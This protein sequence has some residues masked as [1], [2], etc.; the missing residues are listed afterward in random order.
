MCGIAGII[1]NEHSRGESSC[2]QHLCRSL[3][4]RGPDDLG[5]L[6]WD[7]R[8]SVHVARSPEVVQHQWVGLLHCRLAIVDLSET[9]WQP[10]STPDG[11]YHLVFNGEIYNYL[12]LRA[13]LERLGY[14]FRSHSDSEVLL[15]AYAHWGVQMLSR[16]VGMFAFA[17]LD[18]QARTLILVR[19]FFGI[20]PLYY[21]HGPHG[22]LFASEIKTLLT[23]PGVPR[24]AHP[25]RLYDYLRFGLTDHGTDTLF[26]NIQQIPAAH[27]LQLPLDCPQQGQ[28]VHY[29]QVDHAQ[30]LML[31]F[32]EAASTLR[33][34]FLD[35]VRLH[36][37][38]D[39]PVGAAL[40]GGIDSSAIVMAMRYLQGACLELHT[41]S[42]IA[43][44][45]SLN[46]ELWVD[47]VCQASQ[48]VSH[49]VHL[50]PEALL[51]DLDTLMAIQEEPFGS[52][53]LYAQM[54]VFRLAHE[55]GIKVMLDGQGADELFGGYR[56]HLAARLASLVR[57][58]Q[59]GQAGHLL[60]QA[61]HL[62]G[63][64]RLMMLSRALGVLAWA[65]QRL[66]PPW[67]LKRYLFPPWLNASWFAEHS[68]VAQPI[69]HAHEREVLREHLAQALTTN[70]L[71]MLLRYEDRSSMAFAVESRTPFLTP[72]LVQ[73]V[74]ALPE[75][76]LIAADGTSKAVFR[77]AM[78]GLVPNAIL[79]RQDKIGFATPERHWLPILRPWANSVLQSE[80]AQTLP[81]IRL[82]VI[83]QQWQAICTGRQPWDVRVWRWLN[84]ICWAQHFQVRFAP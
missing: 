59:W 18:T 5:Y 46:E 71:P 27:Y 67:L 47:L 69:W 13:E 2:V 41:F 80:V 55:S 83:Q 12:E 37:R 14:T 19:D 79:D 25:Q 73:Y 33:D 81:A 22:F 45:A 48:A 42:Y 68:T 77:R 56:P 82:N 74:S 44:D 76:Y 43:D 39:V 8:A 6:G 11:R 38:S 52:T 3:R 15:R 57:Q 84:V 29:W 34:L 53:S 36:L 23:C 60:T 51:A 26:A 63:V 35:N 58:G 4:H 32:E 31:S 72:A 20:K 21:T 49:K 7:G 17:V 10:M 62:P 78:R 65:R 64:G 1:Y 40:S 30:R 50:S 54:R 75:E 24:T 66:I 61:A 70:S 9:A 16:L 28:F